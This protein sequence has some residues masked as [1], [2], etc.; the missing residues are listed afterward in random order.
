MKITLQEHK[1]IY[2]KLNSQDRDKK[3]RRIWRLTK[4]KAERRQR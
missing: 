2:T 4:E 1:Y 3:N